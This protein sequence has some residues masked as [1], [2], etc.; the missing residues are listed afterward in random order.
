[1][2]KSLLWM[3]II[4]FALVM[5][6]C[7]NYAFNGNIELEIADFKATD[8]RGDTVTLDDLKGEPWLAM[9]IFTNCDTICT[10]MTFNMADIQQLMIEEGLEDY[11]IVAFSVD[12]VRD[13]PEVLKEYLSFYNIADESKWHLLTDYD[14]TWIEQFARNSFQTHVKMPTNGDQVVHAN[15]FYLVDEQGVA[16]KNYTGYSQDENGVQKETIAIDVK[17]LIEERLN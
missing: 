13:T 8:H 15:T 16:V 2:K 5:S 14:Q 10:P 6:G 9:F 1:M 4:V 17:T 11:K 12:P 7:S 3:S